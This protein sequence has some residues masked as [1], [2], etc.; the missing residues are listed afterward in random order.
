MHLQ[1]NNIPSYR[2]NQLSAQLDY[3][4]KYHLGSECRLNCMEDRES[5]YYHKSYNPLSPIR[6]LGPRRERHHLVSVGDPRA[7]ERS[8]F[9]RDQ[10][11]FSPKMV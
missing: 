6:H 5:L 3:R 7:T 1:Q 10:L 11:I 9:N 8:E 2:L 4:D